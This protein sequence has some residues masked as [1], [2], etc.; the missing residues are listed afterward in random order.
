MDKIY[1][2]KLHK[3]TKIPSKSVGN[4]GYD[5]YACFEEDSISIEPNEI[6][7]IP[8]KLSSYLPDDYYLQL[9]ERGS[10]G[11]RGLSLRC[12]VIDSSFLGEIFIPINNTT[13]K[14]IVITK[15]PEEADNFWE[16]LKT[17]YPYTKAICQAVLLPVPKVEVVEL[18]KE[19]FQK[20]ESDRGKG[21]LG[22]SG[23]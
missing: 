12:G 2:T 16:D 1:F 9:Q 17:I 20:I 11:T 7:L 6:K 14:T 18:S 22:D 5:I 3:E 19:E 8:T 4:A 21:M 15:Y 23:K 10:T 13:N